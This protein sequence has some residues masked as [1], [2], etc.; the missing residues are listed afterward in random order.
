MRSFLARPPAG[1]VFSTG[2]K[3]RITE[4]TP[5]GR[6]RLDALARYLQEAA[7]DDLVDA[8]WREP[9]FWLV[10]R[11]AVAVRGF[12]RLGQPVGPHTFCSATGRRWAERTT[13]LTG[14]GGDLV[15]ATAVWA[16]VGRA[17]GRP[18]ILGPQFH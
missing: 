12:S 5:S 17:D 6:L 18:A 15:Q 2:R 9:Q 3:V 14:P 1:R 8:G 10:R 16:A 13:T 4:V 11:A 7:E